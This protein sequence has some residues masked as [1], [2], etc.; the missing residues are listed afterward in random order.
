[1][2]ELQPELNM[3]ELELKNKA[4]EKELLQEVFIHI[5]DKANLQEKVRALEKELETEKN[6]YKRAEAI[7]S[8]VAEANEAT[9]QDYLNKNLKME[10]ELRGE[11]ECLEKKRGCITPQ[12]WGLT[13]SWW[14]D[15]CIKMPGRSQHASYPFK[16]I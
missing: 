12:C 7:F 10:A 15:E 3:P 1:M 2:P 8:Q 9:I 14:C 4:L 5:I 16:R 13:H 6:K 11:V